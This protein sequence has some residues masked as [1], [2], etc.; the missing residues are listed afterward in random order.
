MNR[1][2]V[3]LA[4]GACARSRPSTD[5]Q[6]PVAVAPTSPAP[7][8]AQPPPPPPPAPRSPQAL[9]EELKALG[10]RRG[11]ELGAASEKPDEI[12]ALGPC[13]RPDPDERAALRARV[14]AWIEQTT[15][16][17]ELPTQ[18]P[19]QLSLRFGCVEPTGVVIAA[20]MDRWSRQGKDRSGP[21]VGHWWTLRATR[22]EAPKIASLSE[23]TGIAMVRYGQVS[24][25]G[26]RRRS[27]SPTS[28]AMGRWT[29][30]WRGSRRSEA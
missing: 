5:E 7:A 22:E 18:E 15:A 6:A 13:Q 24:W 1:L 3:L 26:T 2:V 20:R 28:M 23:T 12:T 25:R 27:R 9:V 17:T 16:R 4:I 8:V 10:E 30:S 21:D 29:R 19:E 11:R 14:L